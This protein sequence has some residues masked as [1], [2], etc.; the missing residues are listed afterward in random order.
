MPNILTEEYNRD[1]LKVTPV[2]SQPINYGSSERQEAYKSVPRLQVLNC[3]KVIK[4]FGSTLTIDKTVYDLSYKNVLDTVIIL[5]HEGIEV[6]FLEDTVG[7]DLPALCIKDFLTQETAE[8]DLNHLPFNVNTNISFKSQGIIVLKESKKPLLVIDSY[9]KKK[10]FESISNFVTKVTDYKVTD[11]VFLQI[12]ST[13]FLIKVNPKAFT[14][15]KTD[16][17]TRHMDKTKS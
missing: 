12:V 5:R 4:K 8:C 7:W 11:K 6:S 3:E 9:Q 17:I 15:T 13:D 1:N 10:S 16:T 2:F 14:T